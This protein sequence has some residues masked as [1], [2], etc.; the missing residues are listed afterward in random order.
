MPITPKSSIVPDGLPARQP[1]DRNGSARSKIF[2]TPVSIAAMRTFGDLRR[3][4]HN[5]HVPILLEGESGSGKTIL[6]R[7][8]HEH[9]PRSARPFQTVVLSALDDALAGPALFG[10]TAGAFT[11]ARHARAGAFASAAGGTLFLDEIG[12]ASRSVQLKLLDALETGEIQPIGADKTHRVDVRIVVATN[13]PL[14]DLVR[15]GLFLRDLWA[16]LEAFR[17]HIPPLRERRADIPLLVESAIRRLS[18]T[19]GYAKP[20]EV[21]DELMNAIRN[22]PWP[23]N[24]RELDTSL[25][26]LLV[27]A[28]GATPLTLEHCVGSLSWLRHSGIA[29]GPLTDARVDDAIA[30]AGSITGAAKQLGV[31]RTTVHRHQRK[32][33]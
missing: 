1:L 2:V 33:K 28:D 30:R 24:I 25:Q 4:A 8:I 26:R 3:L 12:K 18:P 29:K 16:R 11:D 20:P 17:V 9:S 14:A 5:A 10:H 19:F 15:D 22:A 27:D 21:D 7:W 31:D 6:A 13:V 32:R 23:L